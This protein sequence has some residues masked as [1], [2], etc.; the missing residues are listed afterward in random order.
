MALQKSSGVELV[1][2]R[3]P[4]FLMVSAAVVEF[5]AQWV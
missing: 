3:I 1:G 4:D 5:R 2:W